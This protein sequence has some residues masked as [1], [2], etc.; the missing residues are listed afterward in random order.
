MENAKCFF[1]ICKWIQREIHRNS[2]LAFFPSLFE[3]F[4]TPGIKI[5]YCTEYFEEI[6]VFLRRHFFWSSPLAFCHFREDAKFHYNSSIFVRV[7]HFAQLFT[8]KKICMDT[9]FDQEK[10]CKCLEGFLGWVEWELARPFWAGLSTR[11]FWAGLSI[12]PFWADL[13]TRPSRA[14]LNSWTLRNMESGLG[15]SKRGL[16]KV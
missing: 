4:F 13:S 5:C 12:R 10:F 3:L 7:I 8:K 16:V 9:K 15:E 2:I 6:F 11:P 14:D 1:L